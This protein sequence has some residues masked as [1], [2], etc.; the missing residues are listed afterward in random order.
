[1]CRLK[2]KHLSCAQLDTSV[3]PKAD[4]PQ[5]A[6]H[7]SRPAGSHANAAATLCF[8]NAGCATFVRRWYRWRHTHSALR[9]HGR[10]STMYLACYRL[11]WLGL[12]ARGCFSHSCAIR[13][14][15]G[16]GELYEYSGPKPP[17]KPKQRRRA[18]AGSLVRSIAAFIS[19]EH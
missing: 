8:P 7:A 2:H 10:S 11:V 6:Q 1:M 5:N 19:F 9:R 16:Q 15:S 18:R 17:S 14:D 12:V 4:R 13:H 3:P